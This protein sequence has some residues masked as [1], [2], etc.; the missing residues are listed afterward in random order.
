MKIIALLPARNE[1]WILPTYLSSV[2]PL[3]D[4]IIAINDRSTDNTRQILEDAG[5]KVYENSEFL[6]SGWAEFSTR[7]KL[8]ELGRQSGGTHFIILD[9]DET[10][11]ANFI[12]NGREAIERLQ[13]GQKLVFPWLFLWKSS[14]FYMDDKRCL[15]SNNSK[16]I[17]FCDKPDLKYDYSFMHVDRTPGPKTPET[18]VNINK[19]DGV[20]F[21]FAYVDFKNS[22]LQQAWL[23]CSDLIQEK[24]NYVKINNK[25]YLPKGG[26]LNL[27]SVPGEWLK[28]LTL[29]AEPENL[30][31]SWHL[32]AIL[33]FFDKYGIEFF[34]PLEIWDISELNDE[35]IKRV[36]RKPKSSKAH[37]YLQPI[38]KLR[39]K[40]I[41]IRNKKI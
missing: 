19:K 11:S 31:H 1:S 7:Q 39:R 29:P 13:P 23:R 6:K 26:D 36:G 21:H 20:C 24:K 10:L 2:K 34:E 17:I 25:Y 27:S 4:E 41:S 15:F 28:G 12:K 32:P 33:D 14:G 9:A 38:I 35:F 18:I 37:I 22:L 16:D 3:A 40:L 8:L 30:P 5:A